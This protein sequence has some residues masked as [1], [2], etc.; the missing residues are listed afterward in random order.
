[1]A[2]SGNAAAQHRR[3]STGGYGPHATTD[4]A[5]TNV[6][7]RFGLVAA[8]WFSY[9]AAEPVFAVSTSPMPVEVQLLATAPQRTSS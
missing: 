6:V 3:G 9:V 8:L 5:F 1:M 2:G 4:L 7:K